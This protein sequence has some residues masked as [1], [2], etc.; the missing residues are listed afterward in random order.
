MPLSENLS[1]LERKETNICPCLLSAFMNQSR[2][3]L[4]VVSVG[5]RRRNKILRSPEINNGVE[6][7]KKKV[8]LW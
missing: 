5:C 7:L 3:V 4:R 2:K 8:D 1:V 6:I